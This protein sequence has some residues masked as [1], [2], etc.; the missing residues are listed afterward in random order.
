MDE[1]SQEIVN[2][3]VTEGVVTDCEVGPRLITQLAPYLRLGAH[4]KIGKMQVEG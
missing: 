1:N 3:E 2:L 4:A